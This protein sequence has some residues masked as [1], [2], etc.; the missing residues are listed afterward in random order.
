MKQGIRISH[1]S[2]W[3]RQPNP[4]MMTSV[5][6]ETCLATDSCDYAPYNVS[7]VHQAI[8]QSC[9]QR[10]I[11]CLVSLDDL[12]GCGTAIW[13]QLSQVIPQL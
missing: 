13:P 7:C 6:C 3:L 5:P 8:S 11:L 12:S 10:S 9:S 1:E 2:S 4:L